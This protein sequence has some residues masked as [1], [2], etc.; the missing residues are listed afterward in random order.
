MD[1]DA[2][3]IQLLGEIGTWLGVG[4]AGVAAAFDPDCIV[5]GGGVSA[6]GDLLLGPTRL[7][8]SRNLVGRGHR[9]EPPILEA[10]LGRDASFIGAADMARSA[11]RRSRR[12][13]RGNRTR[14]PLSRRMLRPFVDD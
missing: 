7:A 4:L 3:A 1:G 2:L 6:A 14:E 13:R 10:A 11:A 12:I 5:V 8:F 9:Q